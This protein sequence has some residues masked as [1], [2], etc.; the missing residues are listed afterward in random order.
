MP[1]SI[2]LPW[3]RDALRS[4]ADAEA[5]CWVDAAASP[6]C[7]RS[8]SYSALVEMA[9][10]VADIVRRVGRPGTG[11]GLCLDNGLA[12]VACQLGALWAGSHFVPLDTPAA[13]PQLSGM[14]ERSG[15]EV[16]FCAPHLTDELATVSEACEHA[17][18]V[19]VI[20]DAELI[21]PGAARF[22]MKGGGAA[23]AAAAT[24]LLQPLPPEQDRVCTF[25]TSGTTGAPKPVHDTPEQWAAFAAA[26]VKAWH[27]T[28]GSRALPRR[29]S[30]PRL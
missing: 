20:D 10:R 29:A 3:T 11:V 30:N 27:I 1:G 4:W 23:T 14:L 26:A 9:D 5:V 22:C 25:H 16:V 28:S 2:E 17:V 24:P 6:P 18:T 7:A 13:Q 21:K 12:A 8:V 19:L 15:I